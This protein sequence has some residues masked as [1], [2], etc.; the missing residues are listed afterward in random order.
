M[1]DPAELLHVAVAYIRRMSWEGSSVN[2]EAR[3]TLDELRRM[4]MPD[5]VGRVVPTADEVE[6]TKQLIAEVAGKGP[7]D[8]L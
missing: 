3:Q 8:G 4:G 7:G 6:K 1:A 2:Y 5:D